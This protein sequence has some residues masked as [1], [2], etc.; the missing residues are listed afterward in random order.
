MNHEQIML[1]AS[2]VLAGVLALA[3]LLT[4]AYL[5]RTLSRMQKMLREYQEKGSAE[6][7]TIKETRESKL[8]SSLERILQQASGKEEKARRERDEVSALM[9]DLSHQL[10]TPMANVRMYTELLQDDTLPKEQRCRFAGLAAAQAEK[11]QWLLESMLK[12]SQLERGMIAFSAEFTGIRET[13]GRAVSG[14]YAQAEEK[15][16]TLQVEP[17]EEK[18]LWHDPRWTAEALGNI[19]DNAVKYSPEGSTIT[20]RVQP[21]EIYTQIEIS[22]EGIGIVREEYNK[23]FRRFYRGRQTRQ[24]AGSGLGL[25]LAQ[26]ILN[27]EKGYITVFSRE[28]AGSSFRVFLMN[29]VLTVL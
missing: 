9:S 19:L 6:F 15:F 23:I 29:E 17:F 25:Y 24:S 8:E 21:M 13:I 27:K 4:G 10:K 2:F 16:I 3:A 11:M 18:R 12:A 14:I 1:I 28:G 20:V 22:D 5:L 7:R 26:L